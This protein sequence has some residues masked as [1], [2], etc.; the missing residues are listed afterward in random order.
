VSAPPQGLGGGAGITPATYVG[1]FSGS[2]P[3]NTTSGQWWYRIDLGQVWMNVNGTATPVQGVGAIT[4]VSSNTTIANTDVFSTIL[5]LNG[6]TLTIYGNVSFHGDVIIEGGATLQS[7]N[8]NASSTAAQTNNYYFYGRLFLNGTYT[9]AQYNTDNIQTNITLTTTNVVENT[10]VSP[11][12]SGA[13]T[14]N[15]P[16]GIT[17][18][19]SANLTATISTISGSGTLIF[20]SNYTLNISSGYTVTFSINT[21]MNANV[22]GAGTLS[23][24]SGYTL[25][26]NTNYTI[27]SSGLQFTGSGTLSIGS[28]YTLAISTNVTWTLSISGAG[29]LSLSSGYTFTLGANISWSMSALPTISINLNG[30]TFTL[31]ANYTITSQPTNF[32]GS[33][34]LAVASGYT[35]TINASTTWTLT[36]PL[37]GPGALSV[38]SGYTLTI[39]ANVTW[40][41]NISGAGALSVSSGYTLTQGAAISMSI[42][43]VTVAG[44]W[45]NAGYGITIPSGA[46]VTWTTTGSLTTA[47]TPG[48]LTINGTLYYYG[49][50]LLHAAGAEVALP[51]FP[52]TFAGTGIGLLSQTN[53]SSGGNAISLVNVALSPGS[54]SSASTTPTD[55]TGWATITSVSGSAVG[56]YAFEAYCSFPT[57]G[58]LA[59]IYIGTAN[60]TY[61]V[62]YTAGS[63]FGCSSYYTG[64]AR[65]NYNSVGTLTITATLYM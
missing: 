27:T 50:T 19:V 51:S 6:A 42:S 10:T 14:L 41:I 48:T 2:N 28:G 13:G 47:S 36:I 21:T 5:V 18:T 62:N 39:G 43:T 3:S 7:S 46:T 52:L 22:S 63:A 55:T 60:Y 32:S 34:A 44:T 64:N 8:P 54:N 30:Y 35:L 33:G 25:T 11:T 56:R 49:I 37:A 58:E 1:T 23:V 59:L 29:T 53:T 4:V 45:A 40:S 31:A 24:S 26:L 20:S 61:T 17:L 57:Y 65:N 38:S 9:I 12:I 15:I 16:S